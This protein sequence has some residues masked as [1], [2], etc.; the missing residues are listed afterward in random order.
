MKL[1]KIGKKLKSALSLCLSSLK[2]FLTSPITKIAAKGTFYT[3][4]AAIYLFSLV[5]PSILVFN[6]LMQPAILLN[7]GVPIVHK[8]DHT[9]I[10]E[11][12]PHSTWDDLEPCGKYFN[13]R[14]EMGKALQ[15]VNTNVWP[16]SPLNAQK[17]NPPRCFVVKA[18]SPNV[19]SS[20]KMGFNFIPVFDG[21]RMGGVV[22]VYQPETHTVF[23]V[24]NVDAAMIY[25]HELQHYFLHLHDPE[26]EGGGHHQNIWRQCEPPYYEPSIKVKVQAKLSE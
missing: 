8:A 10:H 22:G 13:E 9:L 19:F 26:T 21:L 16:D 17:L 1:S 2:T 12:F 25:R 4:K 15:C 6:V 14:E 20:D 23:V 24:E 3:A 11:L 18:N 5:L 7:R